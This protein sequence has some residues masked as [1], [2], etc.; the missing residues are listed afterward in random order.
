MPVNANVMEKNTASSSAQ[1][2]GISGQ[3]A[4]KLVEIMCQ[5]EGGDT[6]KCLP[7]VAQE[8]KPSNKKESRFKASRG[9]KSAKE[10][11]S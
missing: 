9:A 7:H 4:S 8:E 2:S 5:A 10:D 11:K 6:D 1:L 3:S